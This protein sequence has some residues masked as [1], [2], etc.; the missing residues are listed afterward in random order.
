MR[1][2]GGKEVLCCFLPWRD[3][4]ER[5]SML[6]PFLGRKH[7]KGTRGRENPWLSMRSWG[8]GNEDSQGELG[9]E[10]LDLGLS[11]I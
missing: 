2:E 9:P 10:P 7:I 6:E 11:W 5:A 4:R 1:R 8:V 3:A